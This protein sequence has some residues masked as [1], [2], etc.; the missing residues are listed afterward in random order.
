M[1]SKVVPKDFPYDYVPLGVTWMRGRKA[2]LVRRHDREKHVERQ[3]QTYEEALAFRNETYADKCRPL[4]PGERPY[5]VLPSQQVINR[6]PS[7]EEYTATQISEMSSKLDYLM[8]AL[9][10]I[11][12]YHLDDEN[13]FDF[14]ERKGKFEFKEPIEFAESDND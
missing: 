11:I 12:N 10:T 8:R 7:L 1:V 4:E 3:F 6:K 5:R 13:F 2:W 14:M 9:E